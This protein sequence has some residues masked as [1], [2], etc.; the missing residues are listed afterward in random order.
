MPHSV[1]GIVK[2]LDACEGG[3]G[4]NASIIGAIVTVQIEIP[5]VRMTDNNEGV[6]D[7]KYENTKVFYPPT[8]MVPAIGDEMQVT[9]EST[10]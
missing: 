1:T 2:S 7:V 10:E 9:I 3:W 5:Y 4:K 6:N 8:E